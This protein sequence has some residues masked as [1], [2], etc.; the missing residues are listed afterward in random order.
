MVR[1]EDIMQVKAFARQDG[2]FLA[3]LWIVS[4]ACVVYSPQSTLGSLLALCTPFLVGWRLVAFRN[5]ALDGVISFR[6]GYMYSV[7]TFFYASLIFACAQFIYFKFMDHGRFMGI[8]NDA[9]QSVS[10]IYE[11]SGM[12]MEEIRQGMEAMSGLSPFQWA[13]MFMM[14]N[15]VIG[16]IISIFIALACARRA[17]TRA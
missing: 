6:R 8:M 10:P 11:R 14:Q 9:M 12:N 16:F 4:F 5:D 1:P 2:V 15:V 13:F 3:L 17:A 7:Y